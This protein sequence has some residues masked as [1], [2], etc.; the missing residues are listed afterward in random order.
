[1]HIVDE[2][3][4]TTFRIET[5]YP[6][7][8]RGSGTGFAI[9]LCPTDDGKNTPM[10][11]TNKHVIDGALSGTIYFTAKSKSTG[12][13]ILGR[14]ISISINNLHAAW[15]FH[16]NPNVDLAAMP[17][18]PIAH[19]V[20]TTTSEE[21]FYRT[22]GLHQIADD[23]FLADLLAIERVTMIGYPNGLWDSFNNL[24][25]CRQGITATPAFADFNN[26]P[27]FMIDCACFP[28]SSGSPILLVDTQGYATKTSGAMFGAEA[29]LKL[30]GILFAGPTIR[31][32][33][34][35]VLEPAPTASTKVR[36]EVFMNLGQCVKAS[37]LLWFENFLRQTLAAGGSVSGAL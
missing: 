13:P 6:D 7:G 35:L 18:A 11:V 22:I 34:R 29:R 27:H 23:A 33:G 1:M 9:G 31:A 37:Q 4:H 19:R 28:G 10:L 20:R 2:L 3:V 21:P 12:L 30:I 15:T 26:L 16:P 5:A 8:T 14:K 36:S 32:D 24:P 25:I 17:L